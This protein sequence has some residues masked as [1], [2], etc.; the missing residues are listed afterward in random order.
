M[1]SLQIESGRR[2]VPV[3]FIN[4]GSLL[5]GGGIGKAFIWNRENGTRLQTL[6]HGGENT[7]TGFLTETEAL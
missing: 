4:D 3:Q 2:T 6:E 7:G 1:L 5:L